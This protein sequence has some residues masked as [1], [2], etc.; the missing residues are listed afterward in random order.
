MVKNSK[1]IAYLDSQDVKP[2]TRKNIRTTIVTF[3]SWCK[4]KGYLSD[5]SV[6]PGTI[7][8][9]RGSA[10]R[11]FVGSDAARQSAPKPR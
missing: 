10:G 7:F 9:S 11:L 5:D 8:G 2:R 6:A 1:I 4:V 3:F